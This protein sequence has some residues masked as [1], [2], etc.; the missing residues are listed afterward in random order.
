M[1]GQ[2]AKQREPWEGRVELGQRIVAVDASEPPTVR[3]TFADG[4]VAT[5]DFQ[6]MLDVGKVFEPLRDPVLFRTAHPGSG[7]SALEWIASDGREIDL[8]AD[9]LR[10]QAEGIWDPMTRQWKV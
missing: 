4:F 5:M 8:C 2:G 7:G 6:W 1:L 3:L 10:M 9:S